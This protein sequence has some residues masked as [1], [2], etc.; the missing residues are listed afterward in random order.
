VIGRLAGEESAA[1]GSGLWIVTLAVRAL[2]NA[3]AVTVAR[4]E[5][6]LK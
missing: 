3:D 6:A 5:V 4:K 2:T 1:V